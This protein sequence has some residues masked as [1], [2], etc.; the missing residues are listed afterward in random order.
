MSSVHLQSGLI[1]FKMTIPVKH[2]TV[3][4]AHPIRDKD[5]KKNND[6]TNRPTD[7]EIMDTKAHPIRDKDNKKNNDIVNRPTDE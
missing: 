3:S 7:E 2:S 5:N 1:H 6:I 4:K